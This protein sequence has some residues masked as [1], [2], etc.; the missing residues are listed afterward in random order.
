MLGSDGGERTEAVAEKSG[1]GGQEAQGKRGRA[2]K[3][4]GRQGQGPQLTTAAEEEM[5][6][7]VLVQRKGAA[8]GTDWCGG[9]VS[10]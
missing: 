5:D 6:G 7:K 3:G 1:A 8:G 4:D 9:K 2:D 10:K